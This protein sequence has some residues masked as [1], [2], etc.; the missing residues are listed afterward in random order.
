VNQG[1]GGVQASVRDVLEL[2]DYL[3]LGAAL[4]LPWAFG[5][6]EIWAYRSASLLLVAA[7][8]AALVRDGWQG[9]GLDRSAR[10]LLPALLLGIWAIVQITPLPGEMVGVLSPRAYALYQETFPGYPRPTEPVSVEAI[11]TQAIEHLP[12]TEGLPEPERDVAPLGAEIEGRW[13]G[14]RPLS[15][16]PDAGIERVHW[17]FALLLGFLVA[18]RRCAEPQV[19]EAY[20]KLLFAT[21]FG[22]AL[23][24]LIYAATSNGKLYWVRG[25]LENTRP[26]GPYVNPTNFA[27]VMELATPWIA[28]YT[29]LA[30]RRRSPTTPLRETRVPFLVSATLLC[31]LAALATASKASAVLLA[32]SLTVLA[33]LAC[34]GRRQQLVLLAGILS[35]LGLVTVGLRYVPLGDRVRDFVDATG[36][37]VGEV[38]R[39]VTWHA[40]TAMMKDYAVTGSGFGSFRDVFPAYLPP[41]E[42]M[43]WYRV[44]NDYLEVV[45]EGGLVAALLVIWL[46]WNYWRRVLRVMR[47]APRTT[48]DYASIGLVLGLIALSLHAF[49]DFNHQVPANA[50]LFTTLAALAVA[51]REGLDAPETGR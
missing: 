38:D 43:R 28:G 44:H 14:W 21:F 40:S 17:Y 48:R 23:F 13:E 15:L 19:A 31:L 6:V 51:P 33:L 11:E 49:V 39:F 22:L 12:E 29:L 4:T 3:L 36:G 25:T 35:L 45:L 27:G 47:R 46:T 18:R 20:R 30:W 37:Q 10:W 7:A 24:G 5:G 1:L 42:Y 8:A 32:F 16:L 34:R 26:F 50:L 41:G 2:E 9:L